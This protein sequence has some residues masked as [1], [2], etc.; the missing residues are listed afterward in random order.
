MPG[1]VLKQVLALSCLATAPVSWA[2]DRHVPADFATIQAALDAALNG[3][4]VIVAPGRYYETLRFPARGIHLVSSAGPAATVIDG[5]QLGTVVTFD[6]AQGRSSILEGFTLTNGIDQGRLNGGGVHIDAGASPVIR[7]NVIRQN[8]GYANGHAMSLRYPAAALIER[9]EI[10]H[11]RSGPGT[12]GGGGGGIGIRG[13]HCPGQPNCRVDIRNNYIGNN[14]VTG[15]SWGGGIELSG[16]QVSVIGNVVEYNTA[17]SSGG[18]LA[19]YNGSSAWIENNL[20]RANWAEMDGGAIYIS[21]SSNGAPLR[22][23]NNTFV[24][25]EATYGSAVFV[26]GYQQYLRFANNIV[27]ATGPGKAFD[28][29]PE[30]Y[31]SPPFVHHNIV[32]APHGLAFGGSCAGLDATNDNQLAQPLFMGEEDFRLKPQSP[33]VDEGDR[34]ESSQATDLRG[35]ARITDGD[36]NGVAVIDIGAHEVPSAF[37]FANGFE[38]LRP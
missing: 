19:I 14:Y 9:N 5:Q 32:H 1:S 20:F 34:A 28:C 22:I 38:A 3:D 37:I 6:S 29:W 36:G 30:S 7:G 23:I 15:Y 16:A 21:S 13:T 18:G 26:S 24:E 12:G 17:S 11:N 8:W 31:A 27:S 35:L 33:G 25:N 2:V 10:R 4:R